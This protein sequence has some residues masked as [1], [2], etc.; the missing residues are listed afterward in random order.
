MAEMGLS[1]ST[2][3][4]FRACT[5]RRISSSV[6]FAASVKVPTK[7]LEKNDMV[8]AGEARIWGE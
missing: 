5:L 2:S 1:C 7:V 4:E 8:C 3:M 6:K